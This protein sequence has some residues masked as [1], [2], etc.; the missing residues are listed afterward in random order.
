MISKS[1]VKVVAFYLVLELTTS[2]LFE[3]SFLDS[4]TQKDFDFDPPYIVQLTLDIT[5]ST[6]SYSFLDDRE[7][8]LFESEDDL[9]L[10]KEEVIE[11]EIDY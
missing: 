4:S 11:L 6:N 10:L 7:R 8:S 2:K 3:E 9:M 5:F 1:F